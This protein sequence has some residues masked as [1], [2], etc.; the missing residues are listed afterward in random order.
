MRCVLW[1]DEMIISGA[2]PIMGSMIFD[3]DAKRLKE[4]HAIPSKIT[5]TTREIDKNKC[6]NDSESMPTY[7]TDV[8]GNTRGT[9]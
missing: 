9:R 2:G 7:I 8:L 1:G 6:T 4:A 5:N 3:R